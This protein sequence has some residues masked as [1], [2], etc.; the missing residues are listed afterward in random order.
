MRRT[1][2]LIPLILIAS[3]SAATDAS[4]ILDAARAKQLARWKNVENY[5]ITYRV[6]DSGGLQAPIYYEKVKVGGRTTFRMVT[7]AEYYRV[8]SEQAGFPPGKEVMAGI[9]PGLDMLTDAMAAGGGDMPPM[10]LRGMTSQMS[11]FVQAGVSAKENDGRADAAEALDDFAEFARRARLA[12]TE[13]V[14]ATSG[15]QAATREAYRLEAEGLS[16]IKLEQPKENATFT[17]KKVTLW[18]DKEQLV[19]LRLL[20]EGE[21]ENKG[22]KSPIGIEKLDLDYK[23]VGPLHESHH[24]VYR[25]SGLMS[26]LSDKDR[27]E[28]EKAKAEFE[29]AK[30]QLESMP[31]QQREMVEKMMKGQMAKFEAM[32]S[33][34]AVESSTDVVSLAVNEGPP[35]PYGPGTLTVGGPAAATYPHAL[36][37]TGETP[38]AE[39]GIAA[40]IPGQAEAVIGLKGVGPFPK[41]GEVDIAGASGHVEIEGGEKVTIEGG[42]GTI[43]VTQRTE[44]R[45][46]GTFTALLFTYDDSGKKKI[47]FS[48]EG[49]FDSGAPAGP[50]K[51]LRGSPIPANLLDGK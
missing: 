23:Q 15:T 40:R 18:L 43:T 19:P 2:A 17:L 12:G 35:T 46:K 20:M 14:A 32:T 1:L 21:A 47:H 44:T 37:L 50:M 25:L 7:A 49:D 38:G 4:S 42:S 45:I 28:M 6:N 24:Q 29:K 34:D 9:G 26:N 8:T 33:G 36:T 3:S 39:L 31:P 16:D 51:A 10:D 22:K 27:K 11:M 5:T 30:A 13:Q 48:A 41:S